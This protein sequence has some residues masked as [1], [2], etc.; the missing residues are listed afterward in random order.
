[1]NHVVQ[2]CENYQD[3]RRVQQLAYFDE[4]FDQ[5]KCRNECD[6]CRSKRTFK[7]EDVTEDAGNLVRLVKVL[8]ILSLLLLLLFIFFF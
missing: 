7:Q 6:V 3:C 2:Y 5:A 8:F 1:M 4:K